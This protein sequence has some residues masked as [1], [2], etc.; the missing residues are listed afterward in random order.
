MFNEMQKI[1]KIL[2]KPEEILQPVFPEGNNSNRKYD[3]PL[4]NKNKEKR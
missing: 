2:D 4:E 3:V 1:R